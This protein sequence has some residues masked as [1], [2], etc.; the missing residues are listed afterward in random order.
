MTS[1]IAIAWCIVAGVGLVLF[2]YIIYKAAKEFKND[3][4]IFNDPN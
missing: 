3:M 1:D 4:E 2:L